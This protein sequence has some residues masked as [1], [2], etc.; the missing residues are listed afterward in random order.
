MRPTKDQIYSRFIDHLTLELTALTQSAL[1]AHSAATHEESRAED[2]H[3]TFAIEASYLAAGQSARIHEIEATLDEIKSYRESTPE[4]DR[5]RLGM[6]LH[7]LQ[8]GVRSCSLYAIHGGGTKIE[9]SGIQIQIL[10]KASPLGKELEGL[11]ADDE[12]EI[13]LNSTT[14][15]TLRIIEIQ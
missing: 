9:I 8:N 3:D 11:R 15:K 2:K 12:V 10:S 13:E 4:P 14:V 5:V 7:Y 1:A 6:I